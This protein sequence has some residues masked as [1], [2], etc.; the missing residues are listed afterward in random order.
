MSKKKKVN[1]EDL[2]LENYQSE[3]IAIVN[4]FRAHLYKHFDIV[5]KKSKMLIDSRWKN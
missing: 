1:I 4:Q 2:K 5:E 3:A